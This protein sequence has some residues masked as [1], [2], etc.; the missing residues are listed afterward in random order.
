MNIVLEAKERLVDKKS[1]TKQLRNDLKIP[2]VIYRSGKD[3]LPVTLEESVFTTEY[4]KSIGEITFFV[5]KLGDKEMKTV[6]KEKQIHPV[7]RKVMHLDFQELVAGKLITLTVPLKFKGEPAGLKAGGKLEILIRKIKITCKPE[8][9]PEEIVIDVSPLKIGDSI[10][11]DDLN[12]ANIQSKMPG[13]TVLAQV[14][15]AKSQILDIGDSE[16]PETEE[17]EE[18]A[19]TESKE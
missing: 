5:I 16:T 17:Q 15:G 6:I 9:I 19:D 1:S 10:H 8:D 2:A 7:S 4:R 18:Q 11:F 3:S 14:K 12:L 13:N